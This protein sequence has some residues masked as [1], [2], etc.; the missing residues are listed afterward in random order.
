MKVINGNLDKDERG[1]VR[2]VNNF[3]MTQVKRMYCIEPKLSF[4]RA[5]QGHKKETKWFYVAK[6]S[7]LV[8]T[9]DML[10]FD[11]KEYNLNDTE[12]IILEINGGH[13]NGFEAL[14]DGSV[15]MVFS[16]FDIEETKKDD[17]R[18]SIDNIKW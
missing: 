8:K 14:E 12:S 7:F 4:I 15:L 10:N 6:G 2:F 17:F 9:V 5:W 11:K 16:N 13:Y 3:E 1:I 18:E